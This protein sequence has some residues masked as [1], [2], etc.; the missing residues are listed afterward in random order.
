MKNLLSII[1]LTTSVFS[2]TIVWDSVDFPP[3]LIVKGELKNQGYSDKARTLMINNLKQFTHKVQYINSAR[4]IN[5]LKTK[6]NHCFSGLNKN[7]KREEFVYFSKPF[8]YS[9]PNELVIKKE[10]ISKYTEYIDFEGFVDLDRL[11]ENKNFQIA[12]TKERS[13]SKYIDKILDKHKGNKNLI[14]RP[15]SDLTKGFLKMLESNRADYIIEYPIMVSFNS[16][17]DYLSIPIKGSSS[18]LPVYIGCSKTEI[19]KNIIQKINNIIDQNQQTLS[20][21]Y[22]QYL[23]INTQER[24]L[25]NVQKYK[26]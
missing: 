11:V 18:T 17:K 24:Y 5:N 16:N 23:N 3:S 7:K 25:K 19:G 1:L 4:A 6:I 10:D 26:N 13:Y 21:Y 22:A 14:Y 12:Y 9:L 8:I 2:Q 20:S 15:G